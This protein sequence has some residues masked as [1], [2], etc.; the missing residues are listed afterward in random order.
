MAYY[1]YNNTKVTINGDTVFANKADISMN[2][3]LSPNFLVGDRSSFSNIAAGGSQG[4]MSISYYLTGSDPLKRYTVEEKS[5]I[6]GDFAGLS[7]VSGYLTSLSFNAQPFSPVLVDAKIDFYGNLKGKFNPST[8]QVS[9]NK[10]LVFSDAKINESGIGKDKIKDMSYSF[11]STIQPMYA[12][13]DIVPSEV[14]FQRKYSNLEL[15]TYGVSGE[16]DYRGQQT[17]VNVQLNNLTGVAEQYSVE[18]PLLSRRTTS[19]AGERISSALSITQNFIDKKPV[20][21]SITTTGNAMAL[22]GEGFELHGYNLTNTTSMEVGDRPISDF[23]VFSDS[24]VSGNL[25]L[26]TLPGLHKVQL[27]T[28]GGTDN[29]KTITVGDAGL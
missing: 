23:T 10:I 24:K 20:L 16:L 17:L 7:F 22:G 26:D 14:R 18:G 25:A 15:N 1:S 3:D 13:G 28:Y 11:S 29:S 8:E 21:T 6:T 27:R 2:T 9:S 12:V 5:T 4:S 19:Q